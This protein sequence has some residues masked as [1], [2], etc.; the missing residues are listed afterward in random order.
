ML[1]N[2][3]IN[4]QWRTRPADERYTSLVELQAAA[5]HVMDHSSAK[6][7]PSKSLTADVQDG[8]LVVKGP[9]G[10]AAL[11]THWAFGQLASRA[12]APA[13]YLRDLPNELAADCINYGLHVARPVED[14]GVLLYKNSGPVEM[15]AVTGPNYG[16][17]WNARCADACV[18]AF[19]DGR[20]GTFRIPGEFGKQVKITKDNTTLYMSDRDMV[21]F[22]ADEDKSIDVPNRRDGKKGRISSGVVMGNSDVGG[23]RFWVASF[24]FDYVCGNRII[25]GL[26]DVEE[27]SIRHTASAPH[28]FLSEVVP[29]LKEIARTNIGLREAQ[30]VAAQN[31]K[32]DDIDK[33]LA[34]R[35]FSRSQISAIKAAYKTDEG[36]ELMTETSVWDAVVATTAYARSL[37]Y[38]DARIDIETTAGKMLKLAA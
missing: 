26:R 28:R 32:V 36:Q 10:N 6:V 25:W 24:G 21:V 7:V 14:I 23:G 31:A 13:G 11:P 30:I 17:I 35:K 20:T 38:Q 12:G 3:S 29:A 18:E 33:F 22:L 37:Q 1:P 5:H 2:M 4:E 34:T 8:K 19:G 9:T 15:H 16:R 27:L